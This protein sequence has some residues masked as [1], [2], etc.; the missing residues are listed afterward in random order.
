MGDS[1]KMMRQAKQLGLVIDEQLGCLII[2]VD[3][4]AVDSKD[5]EE[6]ESTEDSNNE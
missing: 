4:S 6:S 1:M 5:T 3:D 2:E